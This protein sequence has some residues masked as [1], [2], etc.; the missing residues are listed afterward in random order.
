MS[1]Q[2]G[3]ASVPPPAPSLHGVPRLRALVAHLVS[4]PNPVWMRELRALSRLQ[5]TPVILAVT[6][7]MMTLLIA[8]V[9]GVAAATGSEP[10]RIGT[11]LYHTFFSLA[12]ALVAWMGPA[13]AAATIA[14]ERSGRTWEALELTGLG[15]RA[16]ARGKLLASLTYVSLYLVMLAPVG[17]LPFL[18]GGVTAAEVILAFVVLGGIA[19]VSVTFGLAMS[20]KFSSPAL[21]ILVTLLVSVPGSIVAYLGLGVGL[22]SAANRLWPMVEKGPPVWLPMAYARADVNAEYLLLLVLAPAALVALPAWLFHE[23]TVA[24]MASPSDDRSTRLRLWTLVAGVGM[25]GVAVLGGL[26][27]RDV[28]WFI[29]AVLVL[30]FTYLFVAFLFAG[31]PLAPSDRVRLRWERARAGRARRFLGPGVLRAFWLLVL[32]VLGSFGAV[33]AACYF[34]VTDRDDALAGTVLAGCLGAFLVFVAGFAAWARARS[35]RPAGPRLALV[36]ALFLVR[37]GA[38]DRHGDRGAVRKRGART[39]LRIS[40]A[41]LRRARVSHDR[42]LGSRTAARHARR[43]GHVVGLGASGV[44]IV[45]ARARAGR[46]APRHGTRTRTRGAAGRRAVTLELLTPDFLRE[47]E[48]LKHSLEIDARSGGLGERA[49]RRRGGSAE[50]A[51]HRPYEPGDDLRRIDWHAFA[52]T[53]SPVTKLFRAEEDAVVR[54]LLD[55]SASLEL[56][57]PPKIETAGRIAAAVGYL[58]LAGGQRAELRVARV[59]GGSHGPAGVRGRTRRGRAGITTLLRELSTV[60]AHGGTDLPG[61]VRGLVESATRPGLLVVLSDFFDPGPVIEALGLA[62]TLG[63]DV[64]LVQVLDALELNPDL[65][66]D[67]A[68]EDTET[69]ALLDV[70][71]DP[72]AISAYLRRLGA[73]SDTLRGWARRH[74]SSYVLTATNEPLKPVMRRFVSRSI[75]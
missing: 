44:R 8:S 67:L 4:N 29:L 12:F 50:F 70:T 63:H 9:G 1:A 48:I 5:R 26:T 52:R 34:L 14:A 11:W 73:L 33:M 18:F 22:S 55:G 41:R 7:G 54:L 19:V 10:A 64:V 35:Q 57:T 39:A 16:I 40:V 69:G 31:E 13:M 21:A 28:D 49:S 53:G 47:L 65:E 2:T 51:E 42:S 38:L 66:G 17:A 58:A 15:P 68:L 37:R 75:D 6:T 59:T 71:A 20:S 60:T 45:H 23:I 25:T 36:G 46:Q 43:G 3:V 24:N 62:R 61:A 74:G 30:F 72:A 32:L 56:G 27:V